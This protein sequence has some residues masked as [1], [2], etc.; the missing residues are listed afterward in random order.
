MVIR[1][2]RNG[3]FLA[4]SMYPEHKETR[5]L[6]G[7]EP[8]PQEGHRRGLPEVRRGHARRQDAAGS[9]RSSAARATRTATT[10]RRT[11]PP[12]PDPLP[13]EVICPK[14]QRRPPR[15]ASR[16]ADRQ[17]LLGVLQ[18][19]EAATSRRTTSRS[20]ALHDADDGPLARKG[21]AAICLD[22]RLDERDGPRRRSCPGERYAGGPPNPEALARPAR[23]ARWRG[24]RRGGGRGRG[25]G[26]AARHA[27]GRPR[28]RTGAGRAGRRRVSAVAADPT[29]PTRPSSGSSAPSRPATPRR[30]R[31]APTRP[32]SA[33][34]STGWRARGVDWRAPARTDLRAYLGVLGDGRARTIRRPAARGDPLVPSLGRARGPGRGRPV[35]RDRHAAAATPAA[36][37]S[38]RSTQV[39]RLLAVVDEELDADAGEPTRTRA[40]LPIALALRDRALVETAYAAGLRISELAAR[41]ARRRS[42]CARGEIRVIGKGRK[43][44]IGL[45]GRPARARP[46]GLPDG[47]PAGPPRAAP[48]P[49]SER[50]RPRSSSTTSAAR[51]ASAGCAI[52]STGC[53]GAPACRLASRRTPCATRSRPTCSMAARTCG[54]S[55]SCS[56]TRTSRRPR[57]TPTSRPG[58]LRAAYREAHPR[59]RREPGAR[60]RRRRRWPA[61]GSSSRARS[62]CRACSAASGSSSSATR[63]APSAELDAFFAAFRIPDLIFQ[64]VAA[65]ALSSALIPV[66][67]GLFD[68]A[69]RRPRAW[70]VVSTVIN[71]ML[72]GLAVLGG[73]LSSSS[74]R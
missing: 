6:P 43:E 52:A 60:D 70:R 49:T 37:G 29:R 27:A 71:L 73:R 35:G 48:S 1:L 28:R 42:T 23:A 38:S 61:A 58:R 69:T 65:G 64:L 56:A 7:E 66:V 45:L 62:S 3:R 44:R 10:S 51:S 9:A 55:R 59:A 54:S 11:G 22:L 47:R 5:P 4:C 17:R 63:S 16:A 67:A 24:R 13:F 19:P 34:T 68:D 18:L 50:R 8:P 30:T 53:A 14:N 21:E 72:I 41:G 74:R 15:P 12:P 20:A 25:R 2:G 36:R 32:P 57:S 33:R 39:A 40:A 26:G 31:S 46:G